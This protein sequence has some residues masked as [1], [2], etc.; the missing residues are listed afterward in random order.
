MRLV[1][2]KQTICLSVKQEEIDKKEKL[3]A[4]LNQTVKELQQLLQTVSRQLSKGQEGVRT[5]NMTQWESFSSM[6]HKILT[7][8]MWFPAGCWQRPAYGIVRGIRP[9]PH[10]P[11][12]CSQAVCTSVAT[13]VSALP[14]SHKTPVFFQCLSHHLCC[15]WPSADSE[16]TAKPLLRDTTPN[17]PHRHTV[18]HSH[19]IPPLQKRHRFI[20]SFCS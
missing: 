8:H 10:P 16:A 11:P 1:Y 15:R 19:H 6:H 12:P 13:S 2:G 18:L 14:P 7:L 20:F 4:W 17:T 3:T 5:A 9:P